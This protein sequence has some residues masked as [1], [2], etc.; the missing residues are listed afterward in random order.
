MK[1]LFIFIAVV[2]SVN[3]HAQIEKTVRTEFFY[4]NLDENYD[5]ISRRELSVRLIDKI[6]L[7]LNDSV[8][9][10][11]FKFRDENRNNNFGY[12]YL[13]N[14]NEIEAFINNLSSAM[15]CV[16]K[17]VTFESLAGKYSLTVEDVKMRNKVFKTLMLFETTGGNAYLLLNLEGAEKL[18]TWLKE[19]RL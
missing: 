2:L 11:E 1:N 4:K 14:Q 8:S 9:Y 16:L 5:F 12:I 3:S 6:D 18:Q 10:L 15:D 13:S 17:N 19:I 7:I